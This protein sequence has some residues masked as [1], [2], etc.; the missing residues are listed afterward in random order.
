VWPWIEGGCSAEPVYCRTP[1]LA[2]PAAPPRA[3]LP[4][5]AHNMTARV[6]QRVLLTL[7]C[8][9]G[10]IATPTGAASVGGSQVREVVM[11]NGERA[12]EAC[13]IEPHTLV[14]EG[15]AYVE[16]GVTFIGTSLPRFS[17]KLRGAASTEG[18]PLRQGH[19]SIKATAAFKGDTLWDSGWVASSS[20]VGL[21]WGGAALPAD[22]RVHW[23]LRVRDSA[24]TESAAD[25]AGPV[26]HVALLTQADWKGEWITD[27]NVVPTNSC[28]F[29]TPSPPPLMRTEVRKTVLQGPVHVNVPTVVL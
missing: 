9:S 29:Y 14:V 1:S 19:Y 17:W 4:S 20:T 2:V 26:F 27:S 23:S 3:G 7:A 5:S 12:D 22:T 10:V 28:A 6:T 24:G 13:T 25:V 11:H 8:L 15:G 18:V 21:V 16:S